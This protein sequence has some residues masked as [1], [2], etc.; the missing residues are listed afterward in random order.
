LQTADR[1][2]PVEAEAKAKRLTQKIDRLRQRVRKLGELKE[3]LQERDDPQ[4]STWP[5]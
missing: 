2:Q 4:V 5:P 3:Q 1:T